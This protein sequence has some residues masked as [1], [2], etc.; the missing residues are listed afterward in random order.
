MKKSEWGWIGN[1]GI[2]NKGDLVVADVLTM[3]TGRKIPFQ[4]SP[5]MR[6]NV[7]VN[8]IISFFGFATAV[9]S[10]GGKKW[11]VSDVSVRDNHKREQSS[12]PISTLNVLDSSTTNS[13]P[14]PKNGS[15]IRTQKILCS[16]TGL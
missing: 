9:M 15:K 14:R 3:P 1:E 11:K 13:V 6:T 7:G 2:E 8:G 4:M 16:S 12:Y 10:H 5:T